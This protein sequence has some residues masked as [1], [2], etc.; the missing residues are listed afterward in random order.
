MLSW[1]QKHKRYLVVTIWVSTIAFVGAGFVGWGAYDLNSNRATSVAKVGHR[2]ISVQELQQKYDRLYQYY[3]NMFEGKLTQ[4]KADE[5][6]LEKAVLQAAIQENL[7][8]NFADDIGLSVSKD[9]VLKY[10]IVDPTFQKDGVFDKN[11]YYDVLRR[12]RINPTDF[13]EN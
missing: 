4:E 7:L 8:L 12:A 9:D 11:L 5:L 3:N 1:M 2:N 6:G 10:I 13:E